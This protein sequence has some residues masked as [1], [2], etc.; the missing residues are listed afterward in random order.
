M[1]D[2]IN[3]ILEMT[4]VLLCIYRLYGISKLAMF[5]VLWLPMSK[6]KLEKLKG[7]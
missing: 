7:V 6:M 3:Y 1:I 5:M 4:T 2:I